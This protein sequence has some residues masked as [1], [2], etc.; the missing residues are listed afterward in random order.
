[1]IFSLTSFTDVKELTELTDADSEVLTAVKI[2]AKVVGKGW[3]TKKRK[4]LSNADVE[5]ETDT[6]PQS[7]TAS[8]VPIRSVRR[9]TSSVPPYVIIEKQPNAMILMII[10]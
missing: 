6:F 1:M 10:L 4:A 9:R 7:T 5:E 2:E 3:K 8:T